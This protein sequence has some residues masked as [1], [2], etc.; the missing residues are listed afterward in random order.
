ML[1]DE[2]RQLVLTR[3]F[4]DHNGVLTD[5]KLADGTPAVSS[6]KTPSS[7]YALETFKIRGGRIFRVEVVYVNVPY[8]MPTV[9]KSG[10]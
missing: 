9:R 10:E 2:E 7:L 8:H 5:F 4:L 6:F 3:A 1:V